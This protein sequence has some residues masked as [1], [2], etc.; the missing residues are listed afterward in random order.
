MLNINNKVNYEINI[1]R[2][3]KKYSWSTVFAW[4]YLKTIGRILP[5]RWNRWAENIL[6][7]D[8][9]TANN[10]VQT[11]AFKT[12]DG[13]VQVDLKPEVVEK[14]SQSVV[15][16]KDGGV[17]TDG[18][19]LITEEDDEALEEQLEGINQELELERLQNASLK[20]ENRELGSAIEGLEK[21]YKGLTEDAGE[22]EEELTKYKQD[23]KA[24]QD[25]VGEEIEATR[26]DNESLQA[27]IIEL[28]SRLKDK[29]D[30]L[31]ELNQQWQASKLVALLKS[32]TDKLCQAKD[33]NTELENKV[34]DLGHENK[35]L[36]LSVNTLTA[37]L[38]EMENLGKQLQS[39]QESK[40]QLEIDL[41]GQLKADTKKL[42]EAKEGQ[43]AKKAG[44]VSTVSTAKSTL[45]KLRNLPNKLSRDKGLNN[46]LSGKN[47]ELKKGFPEFKEK[48]FC[49]NVLNETIKSLSNQD[50]GKFESSKLLELLES[51]LKQ[52]AREIIEAKVKEVVNEHC[53]I[54]KNMGK[55]LRDD[56]LKAKLSPSVRKCVKKLEFNKQE[57]VNKIVDSILH[58]F[59]SKNNNNNDS[60]ELLKEI[61][62]GKLT[63]AKMKCFSNKIQELQLALSIR[64]KFLSPD[65]GMC[66]Q[67]QGGVNEYQLT[68]KAKKEHIPNSSMS[69]PNIA[70]IHSL[71]SQKAVRIGS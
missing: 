30:K 33:K 32:Q 59:N 60:G 46:F 55:E 44:A 29:E 1:K 39:V 49:H 13:S 50:D 63:E 40:Q 21:S 3:E 12:I 20:E 37:Q 28:K 24:M 48:H 58:S 68:E 26:K 53:N 67:T 8:K 71:N 45:S 42:Q 64:D 62:T 23:K 31:I 70:S 69:S 5:K 11:D 52:S 61:V 7:Y 25:K 43:L 22:R 35:A 51:N 47:E 54:G 14:E 56:T 2:K 41:E 15:I 38:G 27:Q 10:E 6:Y 17:Q 66:N 4:L 36:R 19:A 34:S 16:N 18:V 9:T 57:G 65:Q